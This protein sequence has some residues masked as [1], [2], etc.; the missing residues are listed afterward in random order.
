MKDEAQKFIVILEP[1][2]NGGF[3]IHCPAVNC[4]SQGDDRAEALAMI[5]DAIQGLLETYDEDKESN[6]ALTP[7]PLPETPE[8]IAQTVKDIL[9]FRLECSQPMTLEIIQVA[10]PAPVP[11]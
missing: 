7:L 11:A 9:E 4:A 6:P 1:E 8:L 2:E 3:S 10:V 5:A